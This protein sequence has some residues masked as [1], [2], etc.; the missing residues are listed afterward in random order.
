MRKPRAFAA[1]SW[2]RSW[3]LRRHGFGHTAIFSA[4]PGNCPLRLMASGRS[5]A[6]GYGARASQHN[7]TILRRGSQRSSLSRNAEL[8]VMSGA[9]ACLGHTPRSRASLSQAHARRG[10]ARVQL[11]AT[12]RAAAS[13]YTRARR[14]RAYFWPAHPPSSLNAAQ[15]RGYQHCKFAPPLRQ[16][17]LWLELF[18]DPRQYN[19]QVLLYKLQCLLVTSSCSTAE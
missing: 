7:A 1:T 14:P 8:S 15:Q 3:C 9:R 6:K 2:M 17:D 13:P 19:R 4:G 11:I 18:F 5:A 10:P 16:S 12:T